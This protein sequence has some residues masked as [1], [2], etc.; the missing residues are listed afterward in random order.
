MAKICPF[1]GACNTFRRRRSHFW[2]QFISPP[3]CSGFQFAPDVH[4]SNRERAIKIIVKII[5]DHQDF[6]RYKFFIAFELIFVRNGHRFFYSLEN[7]RT[8]SSIRRKK[9][10]GSTFFAYS[11]DLTAACLARSEMPTTTY[12]YRTATEAI[13]TPL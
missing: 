5:N 11:N 1:S 3:L 10:S 2:Q 13:C 7:L 6:G 12:T 4:D 9:K 8:A